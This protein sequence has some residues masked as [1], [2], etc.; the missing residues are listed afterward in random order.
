[1]TYYL[2]QTTFV[3]FNKTQ[4][5]FSQIN[6]PHVYVTYFGLYLGHPQARQ[7]KAY[8]SRRQ[9]KNLSARKKEPLR[10]SLYLPVYVICT[11]MPE[12]GLNTGR[13]MCHACEG[14]FKQTFGVLD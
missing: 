10:S 6:C 2:R 5:Y 9:N 1:M 13:N 7:C 11:D 3:Q 4:D 8:Y 12:G 14:N